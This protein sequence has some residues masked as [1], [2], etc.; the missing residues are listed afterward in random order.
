MIGWDQDPATLKLNARWWALPRFES[1]EIVIM[2][3]PPKPVPIQF[4]EGRTTP[5]TFRGGDQVSPS[6]LLSVMSTF[7]VHREEREG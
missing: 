2:K 1:E 4:H 3:S 5:E 7:A 6:S